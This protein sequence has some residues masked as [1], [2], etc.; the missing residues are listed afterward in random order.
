MTNDEYFEALPSKVEILT[1]LSVNALELCKDI[2]GKNL[3]KDDFYFSAAANRCINLING[4]VAML[5]NPEFDLCRRSFA[6]AN[7]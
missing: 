4:F 1:G 2:I 5:Q 3:T 7:G 6:Y